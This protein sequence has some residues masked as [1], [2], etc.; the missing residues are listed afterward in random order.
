[1]IL[2]LTIN[3]AVDRNVVADRLVFEDRAYILSTTETA[4]GRG[5]NASRV[6]HLFG[7][8][9]LAVLPSGGR[10]GAQLERGMKEEG[11]PYEVVRIKAE[12]RTNLTVTD[13]QGL[14]IKLN[15]LGAP[16]G[17]AALAQLERA[18]RQHLRQASWLMICGSVP[19]GVPPGFYSRLI[20][21]ARK[22]G[23]KTLLDTDNEPLIEGLE[24][25]P[26]VV[27]PNQPEAERLLNRVLIT[28]T[29][30]REAAQRIQAMGAETVLLSGGSRGVVAAH[31]G[32]LWEARPP[33][34]EVLSPIGSG[35]AQAAAYVWALEQGSTFEEAVRWG[36]AA[37]TASAQ[38]PGL[39][40]ATRT[41]AEEVYRR[42]E[43]RR[44]V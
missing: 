34:V 1:M 7:G 21:L 41:Q 32:E 43:V 36:V 38:L 42:V 10:A 14:T 18:V 20:Q 25:S 8:K 31:R 19:P 15:E 26:T 17:K 4:G 35:D 22:Q 16:L 37:G 40:F 12:V 5:I 33:R 30:F 28:S 2:T 11:F 13:R 23:V 44:V 39:E 24:A 29:H 9:T 3:P 6:I 27:T